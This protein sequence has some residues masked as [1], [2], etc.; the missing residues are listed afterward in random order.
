MKP[1]KPAT[2]SKT[3]ATSGPDPETEER[4]RLARLA[5]AKIKYDDEMADL[6]VKRKTDPAL[7]HELRCQEET[8]KAMLWAGSP[9][10]RAAHKKRL[11]DL[12]RANENERIETEAQRLARIEKRKRE[13]LG[14]GQAPAETPK[15]DCLRS[16]KKIA[17]HLR[18]SKSKAQHWPGIFKSQ[19]GPVMK[20]GKLIFA[21]T[22]E[23]D[24]F[25]QSESRKK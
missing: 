5:K 22:S 3:P 6:Q 8:R 4:D 18:V 13:L 17:E 23:L 14:E 9:E 21:W 25:R 12:A 16:W 7:D 2:P 1:K 15:G 11:E 24:L 20:N 10:G 19:G